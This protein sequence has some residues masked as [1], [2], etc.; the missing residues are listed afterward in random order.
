MAGNIADIV[1]M[2]DE[3]DPL[4]P[5]KRLIVRVEIDQVDTLPK[6]NVLFIIVSQRDVIDPV[7]NGRR[8][9]AE[10]WGKDFYTFMLKRDEFMLLGHDDGYLIWRLHRFT[11]NPFSEGASQRPDRLPLSPAS[12]AFSGSMLG[13]SPSDPAWLAAID[14]FEEEMH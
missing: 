13:S 2:Y 4:R 9:M 6:T 10:A 8:R 14:Q 5:T 12:T 11:G 7:L 1:V 3:V